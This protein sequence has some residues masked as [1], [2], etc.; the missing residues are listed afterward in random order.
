MRS[1]GQMAVELADL[2][3]K[4]PRLLIEGQP[5]AGKTTFLKLVAA[6]LGKDLLLESCPDGF[7]WRERYLGLKWEEKAKTP[8]FV[9]LS[10]LAELLSSAIANTR[11]RN[12]LS[13]TSSRPSNNKIASPRSNNPLQ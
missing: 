4:Y 10:E 11:S 8:L 6:M 12:L 7:S 5:G 1:D 2:L 9:R 13:A 3:P